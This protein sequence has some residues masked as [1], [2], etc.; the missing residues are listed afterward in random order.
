MNFSDN[1]VAIAV[2]YAAMHF[3]F[4]FSPPLIIIFYKNNG[5]V[6]CEYKLNYKLKSYVTGGGVTGKDSAICHSLFY[7]FLWTFLVVCDT[8]I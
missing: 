4:N 2:T 3:P 7:V 8:M 6:F 5:C 1:T